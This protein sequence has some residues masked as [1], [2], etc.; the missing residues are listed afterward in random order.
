MVIV[1]RANKVEGQLVKPPRE[2]I[3][4]EILEGRRPPWSSSRRT[5]V[6]SEVEKLWSDNVFVR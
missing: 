4:A 6:I 1:Y 3:P 2:I 5:L